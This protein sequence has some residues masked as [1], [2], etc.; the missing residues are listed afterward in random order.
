MRR[1]GGSRDVAS[2]DTVSG[3][4]AADGGAGDRV[5]SSGV[6]WW[7]V[8]GEAGLLS[9]AISYLIG[10]KLQGVP[11]RDLFAYLGWT[12]AKAERVRRRVDRHLAALRGVEFPELPIR[13]VPVGDGGCSLHPFFQERL[14][15]GRYVW[16][17]S[18]S[19]K[20]TYPKLPIS[21][22]GFHGQPK[23][24]FMSVQI[25]LAGKLTQARSRLRELLVTRDGAEAAMRQLQAELS[26]AEAESK[27]ESERALID[28]MCLTALRASLT[29]EA[30]VEEAIRSAHTRT[31]GAQSPI[32]AV[33]GTSN[34]CRNQRTD[35][36]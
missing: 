16:A 15:S 30:N 22:C 9:D 4:V 13:R 6:N 17:L 10:N 33:G 14:P 27:A 24:D 18:S 2:S 36:E 25:N 11:Q 34:E 29:F 32:R 28:G 35:I 1:K 8:I 3:P 19:N 31:I 26:A 12:R 21:R 23:G 7:R 20:A 5:A